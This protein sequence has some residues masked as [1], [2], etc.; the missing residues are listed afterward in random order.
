MARSAQLNVAYNSRDHAS[1]RVKTNS[2][3]V[4]VDV[5]GGI[6]HGM[7][8]RLK[9]QGAEGDPGAQKGNLFVTV[10][11]P[12]S[13]PDGYFTRNGNDVHVEIPIIKH[14]VIQTTIQGPI[15]IY[16]HGQMP[17]IR[18]GRIP[19]IRHGLILFIRHGLLQIL[20]QAGSRSEGKYKLIPGI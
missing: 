11:V 15:Q 4:T 16:R 18:H 6:D 19:I 7:D 9:G 12:D 20:H 2:K 1:G 3:S 14:G 5:P 13:S 10:E 17:N 8:L